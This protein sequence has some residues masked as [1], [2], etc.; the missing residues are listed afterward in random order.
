[1]SQ[2]TTFRRRQRERGYTQID[3]EFLLSPVLSLKAKG[4][5][6]IMMSRPE[7]WVFHMTWLEKQ[8]REGREA[9]RS[10]MQELIDAG[11]VVR[12]PKQDEKGRFAGWEYEFDD[13]LIVE[14]TSGETDRR[15]TRQTDNPLVGKPATINKDSTKKD[16]SNKDSSEPAPNGD[17]LTEAKTQKPTPAHHGDWY[18]ATYNELRPVAWKSCEVINPTRADKLKLFRRQYG[19]RAPEV[20]KAALIFVQRD[21]WWST[22]NVSFDTLFT[23]NHITQFAEGAVTALRNGVDPARSEAEA[24][25][26][27]VMEAIR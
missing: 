4:L 2:G 17:S 25:Y 12:S 16:F 8:S 19:D 5:L 15:E 14:P 24:T 6:A 11:F 20:F 10:G 21:P 1:M 27:S 3:N 23:K 13:K 26:Q 18:M 22:K 7:S 9:L